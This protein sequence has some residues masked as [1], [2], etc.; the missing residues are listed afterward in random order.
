MPGDARVVKPQI[1]IARE[2]GA[3][4]GELNAA[5]DSPGRGFAPDR[6]QRR[7]RRVFDYSCARDA[8]AAI[9]PLAADHA[10][11]DRDIER[12]RCCSAFP[13]H[14]DRCAR[15]YIYACKLTAPVDAER[16]SAVK[17]QNA[18]TGEGERRLAQTPAHV[19]FGCNA[20]EGPPSAQGR[21]AHAQIASAPIGNLCVELER[22]GRQCE[23]AF[24]ASADA[25][26]KAVERASEAQFRARAGAGDVCA[27][28]RPQRGKRCVEVAQH[29]R[30]VGDQHVRVR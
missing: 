2:A 25:R 14:P 1:C 29:K 30:F 17:R 24:N 20:F 4:A 10:V 6:C 13:L 3:C 21:R 9:A 7:Q 8:A 11:A 26:R 16:C 22:A 15:E 28:L 18:R 5:I 23:V 12:R 19:E 27:P